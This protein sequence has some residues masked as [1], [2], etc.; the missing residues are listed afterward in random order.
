VEKAR[1]GGVA[2]AASLKGE[3]RRVRGAA[4]RDAMG[5]GLP[6]NLCPARFRGFRAPPPRNRD[7][8]GP[9]SRPP[10]PGLGNRRRRTAGASRQ[11]GERPPRVP[12]RGAPC[13]P[14]TL[15]QGPG[16]RG[17]LAWHPSPG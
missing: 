8:S 6:V 1:E 16:F 17:W 12:A 4:R 5:G 11:R 10:G 9:E 2:V 15:W 3:G 7:A 14:R 13:V